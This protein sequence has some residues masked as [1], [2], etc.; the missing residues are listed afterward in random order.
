MGKI[1]LYQYVCDDCLRA[2]AG[3]EPAD[4]PVEQY[5]ELLGRLSFP[6]NHTITEN[7]QIVCPKCGGQHTRKVPRMDCSYV[8]GYGY[9]DK[10]GVKNDMNLHLLQTGADPYAK[11]RN[12]GDQGELVRKLQKQRRHTPK[13]R[14][15][16]MR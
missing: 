8:R 13:T 16:F 1:M 7:P 3:R 10:K 12:V 6:V 5:N 14:D 4:I 11:H 2:I 9:M 15:V